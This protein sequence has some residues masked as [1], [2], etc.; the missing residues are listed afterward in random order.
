VSIIAEPERPGSPRPDDDQVQNRGETMTSGPDNRPVAVLVVEDDV[1]VR[2][3]ASDI[4]TE[5][6]FRAF[7]AHDA[8]EAMTLL[9]AR[10]DVQVLFTDWNMP[11]DIDGLGLAHLVS[12]RW[13]AVGIIVTSG[14]MR[15]A[16]GDLPAGARFLKKPYQP[17]VL[18]SEVESMLEQED[19]AAQGASVLPEGILMQNPVSGAAGGGNIAGPL[20]EP[21]KT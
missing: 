12:K 4:L 17:S 14:K 7:E 18:V 11:G 6:G 9:E 15:P 20:P 5:A 10:A 13:P 21:D 16:R 3:I 19:E 8:E 1:L 2:M